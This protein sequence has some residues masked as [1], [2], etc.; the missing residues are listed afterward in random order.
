MD[1][2][3]SDQNEPAVH[4]ASRRVIGWWCLFDTGEVWE[5]GRAVL[6][7]VYQQSSTSHSCVSG[8]FLQ[9]SANQDDQAGL[10]DASH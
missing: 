2:L 6:T 7:N 3:S 8:T 5:W 1:T 9:N 4:A 10:S